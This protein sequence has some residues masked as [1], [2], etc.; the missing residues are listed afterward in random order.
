MAGRGRPGC[1]VPAEAGGRSMRILVTGGAGFIG[2]AL[3]RQL[4]RETDADVINVDKLTYAGNLDSLAEAA[5][6]P[7]HRLRARGHRRR[8]GGGEGL[9][10]VSAHGGDPPGG[11]VARRSLDR[12][13][14]RVHPDQRRRDVHPAPRRDGLL[15]VGRRRPPPRLPLPPRLDRRGLRLARPA[16]LLHRG[17]AVPAQLALLGEQGRVGPPRPGLAPHLRP[18]DAGDQ[19]LEQ[20]RPLPVPREADPAVHLQRPGR[21]AAAGLR[22][23]RQRPRLALRRGPRPRPPRGAGRGANP[24][25]PT[26]SAGTT[27]RPTWRSS[28]PSAGCWTSSART[29]RTSPTPR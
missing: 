15:E 6:S 19:L 14:R 25:R 12:R 18:A 4:I 13:A 11:R 28:T 7:R 16:G 2:S 5:E 1:R 22:R 9:R 26:T 23:R 17:D 3:V 20:L 10:A 21:Q 27:R 29:R 8:P 24:A